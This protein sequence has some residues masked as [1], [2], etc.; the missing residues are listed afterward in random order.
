[1]KRVEVVFGAVRMRMMKM[2]IMAGST[3]NCLSVR[4]N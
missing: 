4:V 1:M 2:T 3:V